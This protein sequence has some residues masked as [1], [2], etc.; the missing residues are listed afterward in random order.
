MLMRLGRNTQES[1]FITIHRDI[2][3]IHTV[4][5]LVVVTEVGGII[6]QYWVNQGD[7][8]QL[9]ALASLV[10]QVLVVGDVAGA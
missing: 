6:H 3:T 7:L 8:H 1:A 9:K 2:A 5:A 10:V 4:V